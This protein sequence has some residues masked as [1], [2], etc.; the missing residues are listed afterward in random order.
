MIYP[1]VM[2]WEDTQIPIPPIHESPCLACGFEPNLNYGFWFR[3]EFGPNLAIYFLENCYRLGSP[4]HSIGLNFLKSQ[5][6]HIDFNLTKTKIIQVF[7]QF[8]QKPKAQVRFD[9]FDKPD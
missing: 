9:S 3:F 6:N 7:N 8:K 5:I 4:R 1:T 2:T